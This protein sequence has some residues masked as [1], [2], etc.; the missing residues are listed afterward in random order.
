M[1]HLFYRETATR[2]TGRLPDYG[3]HHEGHEKN[4]LTGIAATFNSTPKFR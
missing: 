2:E 4:E 3:F 1:I